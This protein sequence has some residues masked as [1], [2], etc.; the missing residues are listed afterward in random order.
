MYI[1]YSD[2][3]ESPFYHV[4]KNV[5]FKIRVYRE[6]KKTGW[7]IRFFPTVNFVLVF[8]LIS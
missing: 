1:L 2:S 4:K 6:L 5:G 8:D 3:G 7:E